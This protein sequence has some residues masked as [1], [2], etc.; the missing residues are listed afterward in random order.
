[1]CANILGNGNVIISASEVE[2]IAV[3]QEY[4]PNSENAISNKTVTN[5]LS[6]DYLT[7]IT[8]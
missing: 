8:E 6:W 3:D 7:K 5:S 1:M 2:S 4:D